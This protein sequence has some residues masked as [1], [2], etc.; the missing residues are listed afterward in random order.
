V[1]VMDLQFLRPLYEHFG[2]Y[3]SVYLDTSRD[4][5]DATGALDLR[6]RSARERL[7]SAG[8]DHPTLDALAGVITDASRGAPGRAAFGHGGQ[9]VLTEALPH[10]QRREIARLAALPHVMP[11]LAQRRPHVPYLRVMARHD[12]GEIASVTA[13][14]TQDDEKVTGT[15]RPV[16]KVK[17]GGSSQLRY[18]HHTEDAWETNAKELAG[19]VTAEAREVGAALIVVAG[20]PVART[21]LVRELGSDLA[22]V[23]VTIDAEVGADSDEVARAADEAVAQHAAQRSQERFEHWRTQLAHDRGVQGLAAAMTALR[24][25]GAAELLLADHPESAAS[26]WIGPGGIELAATA[27]EL[28]GRGVQDPVQD[29]ADAALAR[30]LS[31]SDAQL[32]FLPGDLPASAGAPQDGVGAVLRLPREAVT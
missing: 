4:S 32:Y 10:P 3:V 8:A 1:I 29:R 14:G 24:D 21:L 13:A 20:D 25:G 23:T 11:L 5:E 7:A 27:G 2:G 31:A 18:A 22:A 19:R 17:S 15:G 28:T 9:V 30:G 26:A 12:G 6:W 16:H